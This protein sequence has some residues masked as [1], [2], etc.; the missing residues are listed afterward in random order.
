MRTYAHKEQQLCGTSLLM[1]H[2]VNE[3]S[4]PMAHPC[5]HDPAPSYLVRR[6]APVATTTGEADHCLS[7]LRRLRSVLA[8]T[9]VVQRSRRTIAS[10]LA[11]ASSPR[12]A[13][14]AIIVLPLLSH[15]S[16]LLRHSM[17]P[18][19][20]VGR[21]KFKLIP[22][23]SRISD[24][25]YFRRHFFFFFFFHSTAQLQ[26]VEDSEPVTRST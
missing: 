16:R 1:S 13:A 18:L 25:Q 22:A 14:I 23:C 7:L 17:I 12:C 5:L 4:H 11:H 24:S 15:Y 3:H 8:S 19:T 2:H 6:C 21:T 26:Y 9:F 10:P 20:V